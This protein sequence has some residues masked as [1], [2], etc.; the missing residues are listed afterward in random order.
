MRDLHRREWSTRVEELL[1]CERHVR[2][3]RRLLVSRLD[4]IQ[5]KSGVTP[6]TVNQSSFGPSRR[7]RRPMQSYRPESRSSLSVDDRDRRWDQ[8]SAS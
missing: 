3:R 7:K 5:L 1:V 8:P 6:M 4:T 2:D